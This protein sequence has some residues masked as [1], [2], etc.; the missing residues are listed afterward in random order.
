MTDLTIVIVSYNARTDLE[1]CLAALATRPPT[2]P[3]EIVVVDNA[4]SD[5]SAGVV[6]ARWP[7][8]TVIDAGDNL[9]FA[10]ATNLG[11]RA[12]RSDLLLLLNSDT[13]PSSGAI[14]RL[15]EILRTR[16][17]VAVVGPRLVSPHGALEISFGAMLSP[18]AE[19]WQK[20][21]V[22][23]HARRVPVLAQLV[24]RRARTE[25]LVD[26]VSGAC[27]L[28][29]RAEAES[30]GLLDERFFLYGEDVDFCATLRGR[31][32]HVLYTPAVEI[33]HRRGRSRQ[34]APATA[35]TAY[36][37]SQLA[38]YGKHHPAWHP[39]LRFYLRV[40]GNL[41]AGE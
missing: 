33:V 41:P 31:G 19:L 29:R 18:F 39:V 7:H 13:L 27:L 14:D 16:T 38:F 17:D 32:H 25:R 1:A 12:T 15:V 11:I 10:R 9:G 23:G 28:V 30:A 3:H 4:S 26:W 20:C 37:R 5:G 8:V 2:T 35:A 22:R 6:R 40:R 24:E 36:R 34:S 21:L